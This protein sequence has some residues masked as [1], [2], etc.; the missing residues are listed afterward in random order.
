MILGIVQ[1][2]E[3][4][5]CAH[6][7]ENHLVCEG[8]QIVD[9]VC[10]FVAALPMKHVTGRAKGCAQAFGDDSCVGAT[11]LQ[12]RMSETLANTLWAPD[13]LHFLR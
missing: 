12:G 10:L 13:P 4:L 1:V 9:S 8:V 7:G 5:F 11:G 6:R 2:S 3:S